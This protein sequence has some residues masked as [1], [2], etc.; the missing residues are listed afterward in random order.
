MPVD[1]RF[2]LIIGCAWIAAA[3]IVDPRGDFPLNDDWAY[4]FTVERLITAGEFRLSDWTAAN[5][6]TQ[7][8]WGSLFCLPFGFSFSALRISTLVAG[9][10]GLLAAYG[11]L[12]ELRAEPSTALWATLSLA[13][14]PL[15]FHLAYSFN[16]DVPTLAL[17]M[18]SLLMLVRGMGR[19]SSLALAGG[20]VLSYACAL[21]RQSGLLLLP[22]LA[23]AWLDSE[24]FRPR[25]LIRALAPLLGGL[26]LNNGYAYWLSETGRR[27]LLYGLQV[28]ALR[29]TLGEPLPEVL[30]RYGANLA[31]VA[32]Y[33]GLF[34]LPIMVFRLG[35]HWRH[36]GRGEGWPW[37]L[38]ALIGTLAGSVALASGHCMPLLGNTMLPLSAGPV[39]IA[40][41]AALMETDAEPLV[42]LA[43]RMLTVAGAVGAALVLLC[44]GLCVRRLRGRDEP[45]ERAALVLVVTAMAVYAF[46]IGG[47]GDEFIFDRYVL[48]LVFLAVI[49][50][51]MATRATAQGSETVAPGRAAPAAVAGGMVAISS[52]FAVAT[53]HDDLEWNRARWRALRELTQ[54]VPPQRIDGGFEFNGWHL[55]NDIQTCNPALDPTLREGQWSDFTCLEGLLYG[56][57]RHDFALSFMEQPGW[58][59][60]A[61]YPFRRWLPWREAWLLVLRRRAPGP[62][63]TPSASPAT[64]GGRG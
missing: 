14:N 12:R 24:G 55:G 48:P 62:Q 20:I 41:S 25:T 64:A 21:N 13:A 10:L 58:D 40:G 43:W 6:V 59:A 44:T 37:A 46:A 42:E 22:G 28:R 27:P 51:V 15:Y 30:T 31:A 3:A 32:V 61:R 56:R 11:T 29:E 2:L 4:G 9:A 35:G 49:P 38:A 34:L 33:V 45:A 16:T 17:M 1:R 47:L 7:V 50:V 54:S 60:I 18:L 36:L 52:V 19:R 8:G 26:L 63:A 53:T 23:V 5:L 57:E 39:A